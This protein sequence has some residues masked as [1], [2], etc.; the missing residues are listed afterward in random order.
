MLL[1]FAKLA[2]ELFCCCTPFPPPPPML[3]ALL[4]PFGGILSKTLD[5]L[6]T[7]NCVP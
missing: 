3:I 5:F 4:G 2:L 6:V 1:L 7:V